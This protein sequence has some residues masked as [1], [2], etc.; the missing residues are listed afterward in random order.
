MEMNASDT[1]SKNTLK[2][3]ISEV[4]SN[5]TV[6]NVLFGKFAGY[7]TIMRFLGWHLYGNV[8]KVNNIST[9]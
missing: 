8:L 9:I 5:S 7:R 2:Q 1:R 6:D 4:L 3:Y